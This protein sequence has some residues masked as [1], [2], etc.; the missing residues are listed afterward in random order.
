MCGMSTS[1]SLYITAN[2]V[3]LHVRDLGGA[4][5]PLFMLHAT[6]FGW[7]QWAP[8]ARGLT[9]RFHVYALDQR[10]HGDS[11]KVAVGYTMETFAADFEALLKEMGIN[12][13]FAMGHSVGAKT[14]IA[15]G[16]LYP[17]R[18]RRALLVEPIIQ[19]QGPPPADPRNNPM[20]ERARKR[21]PAFPSPQAMFESFKGRP[22]FNTWQEELVR[23]YAE[24]GTAAQDG[25]AVLKCPPELEALTFEAGIGFD[26]WRHLAR[27]ELP[28]RFLWG[29]QQRA[30]DG[31]AHVPN[32]VQNCETKTIPGTTHHIPTEKPEAVVQEALDFF[33]RD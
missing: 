18:L 3:R 10:G 28:V 20:A 32:V 33:S 25:Q 17:G 4:G 2:N 29:E 23:L 22:P 8:V 12:A 14:L 27:L 7:W 5:P 11:E 24:E 21:R 15:H 6:G 1:N 31:R 13:A 16:S 26:L 30:G 19:A 9:D